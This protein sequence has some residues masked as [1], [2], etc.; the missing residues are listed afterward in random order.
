MIGISKTARPALRP[1]ARM[2]VT[3]I[4]ALGAAVLWS[5]A[6]CTGG[7]PSEPRLSQGHASLQTMGSVTYSTTTGTYLWDNQLLGTLLCSDWND[8]RMEGTFAERVAFLDEQ[9]DFSMPTEA[10]LPADPCAPENMAF[11]VAP[12]GQSY[13]IDK[14]RS[15]DGQDPYVNA[16]VV[17]HRVPDWSTTYEAECYVEQATGRG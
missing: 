16:E 1:A 7:S 6:A 12:D 14:C 17:W 10:P 5:L 3:A 11:A 4:G 9:C 8:P 2:A 15:L 13:T